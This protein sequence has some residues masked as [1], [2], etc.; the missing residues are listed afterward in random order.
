MRSACVLL[1]CLLGCR[2]VPT[3]TSK[4][5]EASQVRAPDVA[6][7]P[8]PR[9]S[10]PQPWTVTYD[11]FVVEA[12]RT[13]ADGIYVAL[14]PVVGKELRVGS[15]VLGSDVGLVG[16]WLGHDGELRSLQVFAGDVEVGG[17]EGRLLTLVSWS[18]VKVGEEVFRA[19][20]RESVFGMPSV[21]V[22]VTLGSA[23]D[24]VAVVPDVETARAWPI[25]GGEQLM[26]AQHRDETDE[27][28]TQLQ[29]FVRARPAWSTDV[30]DR[31]ITAVL[32]TRDTWVAVGNSYSRNEVRRLDLESGELSDPLISVPPLRG[33]G[34]SITAITEGPR[35]WGEREGP[36]VA[37][38]ESFEL[39]LNATGH[40][41]AVDARDVLV[42]V[43]HAEPDRGRPTVDTT[44]TYLLRGGEALRVGPAVSHAILTS[45]HVVH[46]DDCGESSCIR[47][48]VR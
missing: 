32:Q 42:D 18:T 14:G 8:N 35:A 20:S 34:L 9:A 10:T 30:P 36:F 13:D 19:P 7:E 33:H 17:L 43:Y 6:P 39:M 16:A 44:G 21:A 15:R 22:A 2:S 26:A 23:A 31:E 46:A 11:G 24:V 41:A 37:T 40:V 5:E 28:S 45:T 4:T 47:A 38:P 29:R 1:F 48:T 27:T 3:T 25:A 12:I